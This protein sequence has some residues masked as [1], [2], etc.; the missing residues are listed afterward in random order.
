MLIV[1]AIRFVNAV[2]PFMLA[3]IVSVLEGGSKDSVWPYI[4]IYVALRFLQGSGGLPAL[5]DVWHQLY[6]F[7][8]GTCLTQN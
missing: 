3:K 5:R 7:P 8:H 2:V 1:V 4:F 6:F